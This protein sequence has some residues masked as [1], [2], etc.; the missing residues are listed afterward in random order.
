M[1]WAVLRDLRV[2]LLLF[3]L[4]IVL[5]LAI[6]LQC[7]TGKLPAC[8]LIVYLSLKHNDKSCNLSPPKDLTK[9]I[10]MLNLLINN[11]LIREWQLFSIKR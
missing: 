1:T 11:L 3:I 4:D 9:L 10:Q 8:L 7:L 6:K 5:H 2:G